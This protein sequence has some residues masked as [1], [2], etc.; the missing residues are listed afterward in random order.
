[1]DVKCYATS[2]IGGRACNEDAF[3]ADSKLGMFVVADG[4]GG[5]EGG[6]IASRQVVKTISDFVNMNFK[7]QDLTWP[8]ALSAKR[9]FN[10]NILDVAVRMA[11]RSVWSIKKKASGMMGSTVAMMMLNKKMATL[12]HVGDSRVYRLRDG[13][14]T[15]LTRDHSLYEQLKES[16]MDDLPPVEDFVHSNVI[17]RALGLYEKEAPDLISEP[18]KVNDTF[19]LCSDGLTGPVRD[20][21]IENILID[22]PPK[23]ACAELILRALNNGGQDNI[24]VIVVGVSSLG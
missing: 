10:E 21:D 14:L 19:L 24:T 11:N 9:S 5:Y 1:M 6:E 22:L 8:F 20:S 4:M 12:G 23:E 16:G 15:Q 17:T 2:H 18:V 3:V 13:Q 7:D